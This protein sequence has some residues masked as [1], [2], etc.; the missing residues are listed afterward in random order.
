MKKSRH[1]KIGSIALLITFI[2]GVSVWILQDKFEPTQLEIPNASWEKLFFKEI[3]N[4]TNLSDLQELRKTKLSKNDLEVRIWRGFGLSDFEG[5]VITRTNGNWAAIH[6]RGDSYIEI[7]NTTVTNLRVPKS[8]WDSFWNKINEAGILT[9]PD[10]SQIN[11]EVY[12]LDGTSIVVET[13]HQ[14]KYR[15]YRYWISSLKCEEAKQLEKIGEIFAEE[16][17]DGKGVCKTTEWIPCA[18]LNR[19]R[20]SKKL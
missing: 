1:F 20:N 6:I 18:R 10:A 12:G 2:I 19:E 16:F 5:I 4:V 7:K 15:T 17:D 3:N 14:K 8:G 9:L 13:N 11:C